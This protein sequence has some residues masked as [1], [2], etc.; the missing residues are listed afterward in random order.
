M[1]CANNNTACADDFERS[2]YY[3]D[4]PSSMIAQEAMERGRSKLMILDRY[5]DNLTHGTFSDL[6]NY[7]PE[8]ALLVANNSRVVPARLFGFK[9]TGGVIELLLLSPLPLVEKKA[10]QIEGSTFE[11]EAEVL[12]KPA[13]SVKVGQ[14]FSFASSDN[15]LQ[16]CVLE[17][18][19]FGR[20]RVLLAWKGS[21][22]SIFEEHG[23]LPLPPYIRR[24]DNPDDLKRYQTIYASSAAAGSVAAPTAGLHFAPGMR[25]SLEKQG[26]LWAEVTLHVGYGTFNPVRCDDIREHEMHPEYVEISAEAAAMVNTAKQEGRPIIAIGTTA[27]R[28]L[29]GVAK[30]KKSSEITA[31]ADWIN[32][33]ITPG[34]SFQVVDGIITNFH[35]PESTLLMLVSAFTGRERL[36]S[37]YMEA[38]KKDYRFFSFGDAM[39]IA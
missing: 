2:S 13:K 39:L 21:L 7:L 15:P 1:I 34:Y 14:K 6:G 30:Q 29:E 32:L 35:L 22:R 28:T 18:M 9:P 4:L 11:A 37:A 36:L 27:C 31:Y 38:I 19:A 8:G 20:H 3:F 10:V 26:L 5:K 17:K 25:E 33:F 12:L 23:H 16:V 24:P